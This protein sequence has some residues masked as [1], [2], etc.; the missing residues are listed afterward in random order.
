MGAN[1]HFI[2][3]IGDD[4]LLSFQQTKF[5]HETWSTSRQPKQSALSTLNYYK[6]MPV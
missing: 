4:V 3:N 1:N 2:P 5:I 6:A